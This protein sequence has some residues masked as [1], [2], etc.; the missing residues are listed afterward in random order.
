MFCLE[1]ISA[2]GVLVFSTAIFHATVVSA[3]SAGLRTSMEGLAGMVL[4]F[5]Q[6]PDLRLMFYRLVGGAVFANPESVMCPYVFYRQL[7]KGSKPDGR[8]HKI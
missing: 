6:Q 1:S 5:F 4:Q 3:A 7:H 2:V 8:F